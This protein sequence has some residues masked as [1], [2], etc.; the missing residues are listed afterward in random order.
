MSA[1]PCRKVIFVHSDMLAEI[2]IR[3]NQRRDVLRYAY[4]HYDKVAAVTEGILT[5]T[6]KIAGRKDNICIV[7]NAIQYQSILERAQEEITLDE[8]VVTLTPTR[9]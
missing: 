6:Y 9:G 4:R 5:P 2:K 3:K 7:K 8:S 1:A